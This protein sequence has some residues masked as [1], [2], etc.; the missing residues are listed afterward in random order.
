M[1]QNAVYFTNDVIWVYLDVRTQ[2]IS[3]FNPVILPILH[4]ISLITNNSTSP[5]TA[6]RP[7]NWSP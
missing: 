6:E 3:G 7:E 4:G 2:T 1:D 5:D